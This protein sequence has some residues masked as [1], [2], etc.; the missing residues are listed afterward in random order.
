MKKI[1]KRFLALVI[2]SVFIFSLATTASAATNVYQY[3]GGVPFNPT[4]LYFQTSETQDVKVYFTVDAETTYG[5]VN[6]IIRNV[7]TNGIVANFSTH[8][9]KSFEINNLP[10]SGYQIEL[11]TA[12]T[13]VTVHIRITK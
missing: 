8:T 1:I 10:A 13:G 5:S 3:D 2:V 11:S 12:Y 4:Y 6:V 7:N 9:T